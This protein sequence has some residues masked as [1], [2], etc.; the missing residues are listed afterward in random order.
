MPKLHLRFSAAHLIT[1]KHCQGNSRVAL[2]RNRILLMFN[3]DASSILTQAHESM[4]MN[5]DGKVVG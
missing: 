1:L 3:E 2:E 5:A 4:L